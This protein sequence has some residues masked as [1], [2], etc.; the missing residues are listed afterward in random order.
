MAD[1]KSITEALVRLSTKEVNEQAMV[2]KDE[3]DIEP[4][5]QIYHLEEQARIAEDAKLFRETSPKQ[6]G[7]SLLNRK[8]KKR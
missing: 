6:Y 1:I 3:Y 5:S 8:Y 7:I 4:S 2:M